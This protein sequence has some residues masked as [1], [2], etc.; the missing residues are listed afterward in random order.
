MTARQMVALGGLLGALG[1][2]FGAFGAHA[3]KARLT[4]EDLQVFETAV[5]YQMYHALALV[6]LGAWADRHP[7]PRLGLVGR[8]F[9]IGVVIFSGSLY[10]LVSTGIRWMGAITPLGGI[11]LIAGWTVWV[12]GALK[13]PTSG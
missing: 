5:R 9:G 2:A 6:G 1:V 12:F 7:T 4:P 3:L 8:L 10:L 11:A 13:P